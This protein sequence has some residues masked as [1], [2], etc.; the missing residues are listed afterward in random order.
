[1]IGTD[2]Q[3]STMIADSKDARHADGV[4]AIADAP[5]RAPE[6]VRVGL[7]GSGK[8]GL[9][10]LKAIAAVSNAKVVGV[11]DPAANREALG[12]VSYTHL[13]LPTIY[14]V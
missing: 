5:R 3:S 8:M 13:T 11:A 1:M 4:R 2:A 14:S 7:I 10:H 9:H 12:A 6:T